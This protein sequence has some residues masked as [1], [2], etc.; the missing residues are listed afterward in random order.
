MSEFKFF[1]GTPDK[2][3]TDRLLVKTRYNQGGEAHKHVKS[4]GMRELSHAMN[5]IF[6]IHPKAMEAA[7]VEP[8]EELFINQENIDPDDKLAGVYVVETESHK[9]HGVLDLLSAHEGVEYAERV[10]VRYFQAQIGSSTNTPVNWNLEKIRWPE[11]RKIPDLQNAHSIK[12]VVLDTGVDLGHPDLIGRINN[13]TH[14]YPTIS[15][16]LNNQDIVGHGT[17]TTGTICANLTDPSKVEGICA[18]D[19]HHYKIFYDVANKDTGFIFTYTVDP[20]VYR[21]A[22]AMCLDDN[23]HVMNLSISGTGEP[24]QTERLLIEEL[25]NNGT[26]IVAAMGNF[27]QFENPKTYPAS[28]E[29][30]IAVGATNEDDTVA[31]FSSGGPDISLCAP[32]VNIMSTYPTYAGNKSFLVRT[33]SAGNRVP[34]DPIERGTEYQALDGTS[35]AAPHVT[36]SVAYLLANRGIIGPADVKGLLKKSCDKV[37]GMAHNEFSNDYGYGRLNLEKLLKC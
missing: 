3:H 28:I 33:D 7:N 25:I 29:G 26:T 2:Y 13:Y 23:V 37:S 6:P 5:R 11:A 20:I 17:H 27:R 18:C 14:E 21:R 16:N 12:V 19:M 4:M 30:V 32:G 22:L 31:N 15:V 24:D 10:P 8:S 36:G 35:M 9:L 34:G 1:E